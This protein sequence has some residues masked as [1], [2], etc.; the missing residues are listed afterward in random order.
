[1]LR[2]VSKRTVK[3]VAAIVWLTGAIVLLLK[4]ASLLVQAY[5]LRPGEYWPWA[6]AVTALFVGAIKARYLFS[7]FC[8][9]N[10]GRIA[11]LERPQPWHAFRPRFYLFLT[12]M[13]VLA[14]MLSKLAAGSYPGLLSVAMLD[15][16]IGVALLG[17]A[18][19]VAAMLSL[20]GH[21]CEESGP[22]NRDAVTSREVGELVVEKRATHRRLHD[23]SS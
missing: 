17:S 19:Q 16:S 12:A 15:I 1:M 3:A 6:A 7:A 5:A 9:K 20:A 2:A 14:A 22:S 8:R 11:A 13:I 18:V 21:S 4:A 23:A 10:L